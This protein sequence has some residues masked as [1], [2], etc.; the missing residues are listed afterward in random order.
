MLVHHIL[1]T[2]SEAVCS[3]AAFGE[4]VLLAS[5]VGRD[6]A[7]KH[8]LLVCFLGPG[9]APTFTGWVLRGANSETELSM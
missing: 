2:T 5:W 9:P 7:L 8:H 4:E 3:P 1:L 6:P